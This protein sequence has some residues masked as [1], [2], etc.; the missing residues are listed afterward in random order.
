LQ[1]FYHRFPNLENF[2]KQFKEKSLS[3]Q[4]ESRTTLVNSLNKQYQGILVSK[5]TQKNIDSL[6][7]ENTFTITT[8]HQLN[9]FTGPLYFLYKIFS[10]INLAEKLNKKHLKH[11]FVPVYWMATEDHD[12]DEINYFNYKGKKVQWS[13]DASGGVG[14]LDTK[15]LDEVFESYSNQLG[16]G[17]NAEFLRDLFKKAYLE[18]DNLAEA[19]QY[20]ANAL[21]K[22]YGL[23]IIDANSRDLKRLL[24]PYIEKELLEKLMLLRKRKNLLLKENQTHW[25]TFQRQ[26]ISKKSW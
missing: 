21:F 7:Q 3:V 12:F 22:D 14:E 15:G 9:L 19:T 4:A 1:S 2:E 11:H 25:W 20:L 10:V 6:S 8:G 24:I 26:R 17:K 18:H 5:A 16:H 13:R 23:V